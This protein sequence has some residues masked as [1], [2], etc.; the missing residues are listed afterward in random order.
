MFKKKGLSSAPPLAAVWPGTSH[1]SSSS[2]FIH[3]MS[4]LA[5]I[6]SEITLAWKLYNFWKFYSRQSRDESDNLALTEHSL[7]AKL[8]KSTISREKK[9]PKVFILGSRNHIKRWKSLTM[10]SGSWDWESDAWAKH[11]YD[12]SFPDYNSTMS[13]SPE[14][15]LIS[16]N[17]WTTYYPGGSEW[18]HNVLT[19]YCMFWCCWS[20]IT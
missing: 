3:K 5:G 2:F 11:K 15:P 4:D 12:Y 13:S 19:V 20:R 6:S 10:M 14:I 9:K 1:S 18:C 16:Q 8:F 7:G 17:V